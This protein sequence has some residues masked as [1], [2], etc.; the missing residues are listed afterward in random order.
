MNHWLNE[1]IQMYIAMNNGINPCVCGN[2]QD[3]EGNCDGSH[4]AAQSE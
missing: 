4:A 3:P 1:G 2:T